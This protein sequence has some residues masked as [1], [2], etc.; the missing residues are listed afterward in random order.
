MDQSPKPTRGKL[1]SWDRLFVEAL[2]LFQHAFLPLIITAS[3][4]ALLT[5]LLLVYSPS[6]S[7]STESL[8]LN[9]RVMIWLVIA[10]APSFVASAAVNAIAWQALQGQRP[11]LTSGWII[12]LGVAP[13]FVIGSSLI[14]II[15][16][17][18][19]I[20][21]VALPVGLLLATRWALFGPVMVVERLGLLPSL[22][23]SWELI[24][25]KGWRTFFMVLVAGLLTLSVLLIAR[26]LASLF[27][28][29]VIADVIFYT[30]AFGLT[31]PLGTAYFV[32]LFEDYR[33]ID[34]ERDH[35][36]IR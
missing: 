27:D 31:V 16:Q 10:S 12:A 32:L 36:M 26:S 13:M 33:T 17:V 18:S 22:R 15:T 14:L 1:K 3:I 30:A 8:N 28:N 29:V 21:L 4:G 11:T 19:I 7:P 23:R 34:K 25:G 35:P 2:Q 20:S 24:N 6:T 5:N 9:V